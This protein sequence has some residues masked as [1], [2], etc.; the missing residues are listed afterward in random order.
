M[1]DGSDTRRERDPLSSRRR[2]GKARDGESAVGFRQS[3]R[4]AERARRR[5][6]RRRRMVVVAALVVMAVAA[7]LAV[8][9]IGASDGN[10]AGGQTEATSSSTTTPVAV[11]SVL[12]RVRVERETKVALLLSPETRPTL[13]IALPGD[14]LVRAASGFERLSTFLDAEEG[15]DKALEEAAEGLEAALGVKPAYFVSVQWADVLGA[16]GAVGADSSAVEE[17]AADQR[18]SADAVV[19]AFAA[20]AEASSDGP[21]ESAVKRLAFEGEAERARAAVRAFTGGAGVTGGIP[22]RMVEGLGFAY[23][24]PDP[25]ALQAML[26]GQTPESTVSVEVQNGS[27]LVGVA[28]LVSEAIAPFGYTLLPPKNAEGFPDVETTQIYAAPDVV[29]EA[30]RLRTAVGRG[31]VVRQDTLPPGRIVIV[32]GKDLDPDALPAGGG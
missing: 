9:R 13:M 31:T 12:I 26:G 23:F 29:G 22:G 25:A 24:E 20:L 11:E 21:G 18:S 15:D 8:S 17:L 7:Y 10:G 28:Q 16:L 32:V 5:R 3:R 1:A 30:D 2:S 27:G 14:T 4:A 6:L 19:A